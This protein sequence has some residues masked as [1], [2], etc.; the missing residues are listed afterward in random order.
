MAI[1]AN[2]L[3]DVTVLPSQL[4]ETESILDSVAS[5]ANASSVVT[6]L[7]NVINATLAVAN[8][9]LAAVIIDPADLSSW[10]PNVFSN[11]SSSDVLIGGGE[12]TLAPEVIPTT[13]SIIVSA[14]LP[15]SPATIFTAP[16]T[17][18]TQVATAGPPAWPYPGVVH[19]PGGSF[20]HDNIAVETWVNTVSQF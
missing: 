11:T 7:T 2:D 8:Q 3:V 17:E 19:T 15:T 13:R 9:T 4:I 10:V 1:N 5:A 16:V 20:H 6:N 12:T 14:L 18:W